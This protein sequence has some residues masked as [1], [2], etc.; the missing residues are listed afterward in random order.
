MTWRAH[1][2]SLENNIVKYNSSL[3]LIKRPRHKI[4]QSPSQRNRRPV[5]WSCCRWTN[6]WLHTSAVNQNYSARDASELQ[7]SCNARMFLCHGFA[8]I[9][10]TTLIFRIPI[11][12]HFIGRFYVEGVSGNWIGLD[13][14][15]S[16]RK[17]CWHLLKA[18]SGY[19]QHH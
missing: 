16:Q 14:F 4:L 7:V 8:F 15:A 17:P 19:F 2:D 10:F 18:S 3:A 13:C 5:I 6:I 9:T 12:K 11:K 1:A